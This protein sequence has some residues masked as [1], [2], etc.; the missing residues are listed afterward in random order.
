MDRK[1]LTA[2]MI[3]CAPVEFMAYADQADR[4]TVVVGPDGKK[5]RF[6]NDQLDQAETEFKRKDAAIK[7]EKKKKPPA[8]KKAPVKRVKEIGKT[9]MG[10]SLDYTG[11]STMNS[12]DNTGA[13]TGSFNSTD[14]AVIYL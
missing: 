10:I 12:Y 13:L 3:G 2:R 7:P 9:V 1:K 8:K 14:M 5:Y 4:G 11:T 6:S